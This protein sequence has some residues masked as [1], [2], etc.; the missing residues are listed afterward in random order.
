MAK[1]GEAYVQVRADLKPFGKDLDTAV[2]QITDRF[3]KDL[4]RSLGRKIGTEIG[5][6]AREGLRDSVKGI[7]EEMEKEFRIPANSSGRRVGREFKRG[8]SDELKDH[9]V[10]TKT[11]SS[12]VAALEDGFSALPP[13]VKAAVG[14]ALL[15]V[16]IPA[17]ALAGAALGTA[18]I[19]G[20]TAAGVALAFQFEE[21]ASRGEAFA[22]TLRFRFVSA[23]QAF[24]SAAVNAM[25]FLDTRLDAL[26][27]TLRS[28][29]DNAAEYVLPFADAISRLL[30]EALQGLDRGLRGAETQEIIN[31]LINGFEYIGQSIGDAFEILL[32]NPNLDLALYDL[33]IL[34]GDIVTIGG[35]FLNWALNVYDTFR[36]ITGFVIEFVDR[37]YDLWLGIKALI[38][39]KPGAGGHFLDGLGLGDDVKLIKR[40]EG[41]T[42]ATEGFDKQMRLTIKTT[43]EEVKALQELQ[44]ALDEQT[45][46]AYDAIASQIAY[47]E[48][49]DRSN[50]ALKKSKGSIDL[51]TKAGRE[52]AD[53]VLRRIELLDKFTQLQ[54]DKGKLTDEQAQIYF[55]NEI[56]RLRA[57]FVARGGVIAQ[58]DALYGEYIKLAGI[59]PIADPTGP[60]NLGAKNLKQSFDLARLAWERA[61]ASFK[62]KPANGNIKVEG[63]TQLKGFADGGRITS[64]QII[65]AGENYRPEII[66]PETQPSR[67]ME[68]LNNS[69]L[70]SVVG[71]GVTTVYAYFDGE[72]FQARIVTTARSVNRQ[73]ARTISQVPR[74]I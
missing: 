2:K 49:I 66:L 37:L 39:L 40:L 41:A 74:N 64:P 14:A 61:L 44:R 52:A 18:L 36:D 48:A 67:A 69:P 23:A 34:V 56:K 9:N 63:G 62:K 26:D 38:E 20:V 73:A 55:A 24:G 8:V 5:G 27:P 71:G 35:D 53:Q 45:R 68:I 22:S 60:L 70:G 32:S 16:V 72:P 1:L 43:E 42:S 58:F 15:A 4:N 19:A 59:P 33:L 29:F 13:Q 30:D 31:S 25:D 54:I 47:E 57:E 11:L 10:V 12:L 28:V 6:G 65:A 17:G 50:E 7:G 21:V 3:A 46:K 51:D